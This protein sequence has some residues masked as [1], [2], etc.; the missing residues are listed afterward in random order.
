VL[1]KIV[2]LLLFAALPAFAAEADPALAAL[3]ADSNQT[4][5]LL[6]AG[7]VDEA[8]ALLKQQIAT[9]KSNADAQNLLARAYYAEELTD[10]AIPPGER[11]VEIAPN[12][13]LFHL[14]LGR[15]YGAKAEKANPFRAMGFARKVRDQFE[16]AVQLDP[17]NLEARTDL[18]EFYLEAPG[19]VG[20]GKDK[21]AAQAEALTTKAPHIAHWIRARL[22]EKDKNYTEAEKEYKAAIES[23][24][25]NAEQWL[26]LAG[27]YQQRGRI[28]EMQHAL[29]KAV[30]APR[31]SSAVLYDAAHL[32]FHANQKLPLAAEL[33]NKYLNS[34]DKVE[35][36]PAFKAYVLLGQILEKQGD[37]AGAAKQYQ[38]AL[39]LAK[40][41]AP[42][43]DALSKLQK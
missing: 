13:S 25:T 27:F 33:D 16:S 28:P 18:A 23:T 21:A 1:K 19:M 37:K 20:G 12:S 3:A 9:N 35:E 17:N 32:L 7:R 6:N 26:N 15:I 38:A 42:A 8:I 14:W 39:S 40:D 5:S 24:K 34:K 4:Q 36:A 41:Y 10:Q 29:D 30:T 22:A 43:K 2:W 31:K 11:A